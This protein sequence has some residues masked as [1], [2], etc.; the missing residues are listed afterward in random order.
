MNEITKIEEQKTFQMVIHRLYGGVEVHEITGYLISGDYLILNT[1]KK[2]IVNEDGTIY[3][4]STNKVVQL[5]N[6]VEFTVNKQTQ[7][8]DIKGED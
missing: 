1:P 2:K 3:I 6:S 8:Y 7:Q 5:S 4:S